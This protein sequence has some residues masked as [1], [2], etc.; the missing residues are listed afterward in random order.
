MPETPSPIVVHRS[1][2]RTALRL[3]AVVGVVLAAGLLFEYGRYRGGYDVRAEAA[4]RDALAEQIVRLTKE[5]DGLKRRMAV[6]EQA[7]RVD[8]QAYETIKRQLADEQAEMQELRQEVAFYRSIVNDGDAH[9]GL[10]IQN[11]QIQADGEDGGY[12]YRLILTR[13]MDSK[14]LARGRIAL[15]VEGRR[16]GRP[17]RVAVEG[18]NR[19]N[20]FRFRSFQEV[21]GHLSFPDGFTP[22]R[23][24]VRAIPQGKRH[25]PTVE[26]SFNWN[27]LLAEG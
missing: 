5:R 25:G 16:D 23:V 8:Q 6:I 26:R 2:W 18:G 13:Y 21:T 20:R 3:A 4:A 19:R 27:D 15:V 12:R 22:E 10:Y 1:R 17:A 7:A 24:V 9:R 11:L 14:R